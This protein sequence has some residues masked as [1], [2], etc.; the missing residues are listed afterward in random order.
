MRMFFSAILARWRVGVAVP[1]A[2]SPLRESLID[3][4]RARANQFAATKRQKPKASEVPCGK[5]RTFAALN[6]SLTHHL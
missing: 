3:A 4:S 6:G 2:V 1:L 5:A